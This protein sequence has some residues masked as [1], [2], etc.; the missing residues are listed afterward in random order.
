MKRKGK[1]PDRVRSI[2]F[3]GSQSECEILL[4][5]TQPS[6][7]EQPQVRRQL[8]TTDH[9]NPGEPSKPKRKRRT[10][11]SLE[12]AEFVEPFVKK[13]SALTRINLDTMC[14]EIDPTKIIKITP[15]KVS[16]VMGTPVGGE[17]L[18]LPEHKV[19]G[20]AMRRLARDLGLQPTDKISATR[21]IS[22]IKQRKDD[23]N[24]VR[25]FITILTSKLLLPTS[26][27]YIT[28]KDAYLG[29]DLSR[30]ARIDWSKA[31]LYLDNLHLPQENG[32]DPLHTPRIQLYTKEMV[33]EISRLDRHGN[34]DGPGQF[35]TPI[36]ITRYTL[37]L[38]TTDNISPV[39]FIVFGAQLRGVIGTCYN[40]PDYDK[41]EEPR[42]GNS[43]TPYGEELIR[44]VN[45]SFPS[46]VDAIGVHLTRLAAEQSRRVLDAIGVFDRQAKVAAY[47]IA[48]QIRMVQTRQA[49]AYNQIVNIINE[50]QPPRDQPTKEVSIMDRPTGGSPDESNQPN[51]ISGTAKP[52][53]APL[54]SHNILGGTQ[55]GA[56]A[57]DNNC[58]VPLATNVQLQN[59]QQG[60]SAT[61]TA[62]TAEQ[63][64]PTEVQS[65]QS[66]SV[67]AVV[68]APTYQEPEEM[69]VNRHYDPN[70]EYV[71]ALLQATNNDSNPHKNTETLSQDEHN[72]AT[73]QKLYVAAD[74]NSTEP[75]TNKEAF[76]EQAN[77][78]GV[79][80]LEDVHNRSGICGLQPVLGPQEALDVNQVDVRGHQTPN[81]DKET[82]QA[83]TLE[84]PDPNVMIHTSATSQHASQAPSTNEALNDDNC[85]T[86]CPTHSDWQSQ[87]GDDEFHI[88]PSL[89]LPSAE[90]MTDSQIDD[91]IEEIV[92]REGAPT[93]HQMNVVAQHGAHSNATPWSQP[94]RLIRKPT[95]FL[96]PVI[97]GELHAPSPTNSALQL[98]AT[99]LGDQER[100]GRVVLIESDRCIATGSDIVRSFTLGSMTEGL[101][102]DSFSRYLFE[103]DKRDRPETFGKRIFIPTSVSVTQQSHSFYHIHIPL[104]RY[105]PRHNLINI[106]NITRNG[107]KEQFSLQALADHMRDILRGIN[108]SRTKLVMK[109]LSDGLQLCFPG[110]FP[111]FSRYRR[112]YIPCPKMAVGSND[113][114]FYVMKFM[115]MYDGDSA[116]LAHSFI[117]SESITLRAQLL[118]R[119]IFNRFNQAKNFHPD[120][121][122]LRHNVE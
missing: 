35:G 116:K 30:A 86:F 79:A 117:P 15:L 122:A 39:H 6:P 85:S 73:A 76:D 27:H 29:S 105:Y 97:V 102:I 89:F 98:L 118:Y 93:L 110:K 88:T 104:N 114:A 31:I 14:I 87:Q 10:Q 3:A 16:L 84:P 4:S 28:P 51:V 113:S 92:A 90:G 107:S 5:D 44:P 52:G 19:M 1:M 65:H 43:G 50:T 18:R 40:H 62:T 67:D 99:I 49:S 106:E 32:V 95:R 33:E 100:Y 68:E 56:V 11:T 17:E 36:F 34:G 24:T 111:R 20:V 61:E 41:D 59:G 77:N 72:Q 26:D 81:M 38:S 69:H 94:K 109:R 70:F 58:P 25:L 46:M 63:D 54:S 22:E 74:T 80:L 8:P 13:G 2:K 71:V 82:S 55:D 96:S 101:F 47:E 119:L 37:H 42:G 112:A 12:D 66:H 108:V 103:E 121:E 9:A 120:I 7:Q 115:E 45:I 60:W 23:P 64:I 83:T 75:A 53:N 78:S 91:K 57:V 21:L 48:K